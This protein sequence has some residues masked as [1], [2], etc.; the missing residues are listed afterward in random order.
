MDITETKTV[1]YEEMAA[2]AEL[3]AES[4]KVA[5]AGREVPDNEE[6]ATDEEEGNRL[7]VNF[8][9]EYEF[10]NGVEKAKN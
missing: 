9:K 1:N 8:F 10:D 5:S 7:L 6:D 4:D 2:Q 3:E